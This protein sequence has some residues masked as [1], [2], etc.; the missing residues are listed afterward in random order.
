MNVSRHP[1]FA[2]RSV[3]LRGEGAQPGQPLRPGDDLVVEIEYEAG[4][5]LERP[6][7]ILV[8]QSVKGSCFA[9][10]MLLDGGQPPTLAGVGSLKCR[11]RRLP[12]LPQ[13]YTVQLA[14]RSRNREPIVDMQDVGGFSVAGDLAEY[15]FEGDYRTLASKS[16]PVMI[17]YEWIWP[18]GTVREVILGGPGRMAGTAAAG[19]RAPETGS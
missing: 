5:P 19:E 13:N 15:G 14:M 8:V 4:E 6:S 7:V 12:L 17:P 10:N 3:V 16:I 2:I 1:D 11:F 9:A 18:D